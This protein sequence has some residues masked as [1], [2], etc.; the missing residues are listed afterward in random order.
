[1]GARKIA[2]GTFW[3]EVGA[4]RR[5]SRRCVDK[6]FGGKAQGILQKSRAAVALD[7]GRR[8]L[9]CTLPDLTQH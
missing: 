3:S 4:Y 8:D 1:M 2:L 7:A 5:Q 6:E 9:I